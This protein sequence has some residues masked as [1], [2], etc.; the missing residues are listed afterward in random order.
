MIV[1]GIPVKR[2]SERVKDKNFR[3]FEGEPLFSRAIIRAVCAQTVDK[4]IVDTDSD[5]VANW[6]CCHHSDKVHCVRRR[7]EMSANNIN[8]NHLIVE[9]LRWAEEKGWEPEIVVQVLATAPKATAGL[10]DQAVGIL[11]EHPYFDS[12]FAA[13]PLSGFIMCDGKPV[14]W[15]I[16][17]FGRTQD[18]NSF[19]YRD[20]NLV[21]AIRTKALRATGRRI[22]DR[23]FPLVVPK[24]MIGD[25]DTEED[26]Q[27]IEHGS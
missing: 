16:D 4:V 11:R 24:E 9:T 25:V 10:I 6:V 18:W 26:L 27:S 12:V 23:P 2:N 15:D 17:T 20:A 14:G 8:G 22:G 21:H 7:P 1:A 13:E 19:A 3:L 5:Q